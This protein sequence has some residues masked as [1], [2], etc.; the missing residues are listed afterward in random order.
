MSFKMPSTEQLRELAA[1]VSGSATVTQNPSQTSSS[2]AISLPCGLGEGSR[3]IGLMLVAKHWQEST[4]YRAADAF[5][6]AS[7][8]QS[9]GP[10]GKR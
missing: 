10:S 8:W 6:R 4:L 1:W 3:P 7:N 9:M 2:R 5:E